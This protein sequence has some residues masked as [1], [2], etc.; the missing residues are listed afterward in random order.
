M[1]RLSSK[2]CLLW[3]LL[4]L[5]FNGVHRADIDRHVIVSWITDYMIALYG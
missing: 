2:H 5:V 1:L 4:L 3:V